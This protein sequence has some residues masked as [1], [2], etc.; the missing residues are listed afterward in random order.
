MGEGEMM[1]IVATNVVP[2]GPTGTPTA[3]ANTILAAR[4]ALTHRLQGCAACNGYNAT[5]PAT[6]SKAT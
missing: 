4:R 5:P 3:R 2:V 6:P 1:K